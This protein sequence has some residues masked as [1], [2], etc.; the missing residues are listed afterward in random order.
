LHIGGLRTALFNYLFAKSAG[1]TFILRI[2]D[3]DRARY[4]PDA[5][6]DI[7]ASMRWL[8]IEWDEGPDKPGACGPYTQS[9]RLPLYR[10][11]VEGLL[12]GGHAYR[13]F[14]TAERLEEM[15]A[16]QKSETRYDGRCRDLSNEESARLLASGLPHVVRLAAPRNGT[17]QVYDFLRGDVAFE[18]ALQDDLVLLKGDGFPTYHLAHV[19]DDHAMGITHVLR[20]EEWLPSTPKHVLLFAAF[21]WTPPLYVH[22]PVILSPS[23]GK[24]SK[25]DGAANVREFIEMGYLPEAMTNFLALLGWSFDGERS[26]F[27]MAEL[28]KEFVIE[29]IGMASP[30]FDRAKL[31]DYNG[32]YI[33]M[34]SDETLAGYC[35]P[36]LAAAGLIANA[37]ASASDADAM[38]RAIMPLY[39]ERLVHT[40]DIVEQARFFFSDDIDYRGGEALLIKKTT[41]GEALA[42]LDG[43]TRVLGALTDF[44]PAAIEPCLRALADEISSQLTEPKNAVRQVFMT[45]RTALTGREVSPGLFETMEVLGRERCIARIAAAR[46]SLEGETS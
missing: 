40:K 37:G 24:L 36:H 45:L 27:T 6:A 26:M 11:A 4:V 21:G 14:C 3:T 22:L 34:A 10:E 2:E 31:D 23:G 42:I 33:R 38:L 7:M 43:A 5:L 28:E 46:R 15:R 30:V 29:K 17:T 1:G 8:G 41:R 25:R 32:K 13:C 44:T 9:E 35:R 18:N 16:A 12:A 19:V 39:R 20:G